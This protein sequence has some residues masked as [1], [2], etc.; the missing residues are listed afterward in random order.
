MH[1]TL[2]MHADICVLEQFDA[3]PAPMT[4]RKER[5]RVARKLFKDRIVVTTRNGH[6]E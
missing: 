3:L 2:H 6:V 1:D 4:V 5:E